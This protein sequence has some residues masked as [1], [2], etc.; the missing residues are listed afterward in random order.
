MYKGSLIA[1]IKTDDINKD[2]AE[3]L[4][5]MFNTLNYALGRTLPR[6]KDKKSIS[7]TINELS[8]KIMK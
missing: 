5:T 3:D 7:V 8:R 2:I 1:H 4:E 6:V